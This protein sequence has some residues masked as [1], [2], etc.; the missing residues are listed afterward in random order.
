MTTIDQT[1]YQNVSTQLNETEIII[2]V[3]A[4]QDINT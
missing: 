2:T 3:N 1:L 4:I